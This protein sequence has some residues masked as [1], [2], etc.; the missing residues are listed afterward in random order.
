MEFDANNLNIVM[1][2]PDAAQIGTHD[3]RLRLYF[4]RGTA[5]EVESDPVAF[6]V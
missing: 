2:P 5:D 3:M 6:Q 4:G 1:Q